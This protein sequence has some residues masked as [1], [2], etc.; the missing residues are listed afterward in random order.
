M[1]QT[2]PSSP[3]KGKDGGDGGQPV[4]V[5]FQLGDF[6]ADAKL[7]AALDSRTVDEAAALF[8]LALDFTIAEIEDRNQRRVGELLAGRPRR[9]GGWW[10]CGTRGETNG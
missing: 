5:H 10:P 7:E 8:H 4:H 6:L 9:P 3:T 1:P 2:V